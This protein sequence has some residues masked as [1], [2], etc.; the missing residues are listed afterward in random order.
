[1][2]LFHGSGCYWS[3]CDGSSYHSSIEVGCSTQGKLGDE[4]SRYCFYIYL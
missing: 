1:M 3:Y 4:K 2:K